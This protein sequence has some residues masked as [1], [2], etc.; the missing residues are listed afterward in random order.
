M[1]FNLERYDE[2]LE[3]AMSVDCADNSY[4][5]NY[6][7]LAYFK[8]NKYD[9]AL[10]YAL[11]ALDIAEF[12]EEDKSDIKH[13]ANGVYTCYDALCESEKAK[14]IEAKYELNESR[15][16][17]PEELETLE[18]HIAKHFGEFKNVF[19]EVVSDELH[20]DIYIIEP[21]PQRDFYT[22]VTGGMGAR[23]MDIPQEFAGYELERA[24]LLICLPKSWN[25]SSSNERDY[26]PLRWLKILARLPYTDDTWLADGHTIPTGEALAGSEFEC[27]LLERPYSFDGDAFACELP[28]GE[29]VKFYQLIP[30]YEEEMEYKLQ[31]GSDEL[32]ELFDEDFSDVVDVKR[33][34]YCKKSGILGKFLKI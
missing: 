27:I 16:Y 28:N 5:N 23:A 19:H 13:Y 4:L 25:I 24:E 7:A 32:I 14:Q 10:S 34:N 26:R 12:N 33:K 1:L 22:L 11:K 17:L 31:N 29:K 9:S 21:T 2:V 18:S 15:D 3:C 20:I 6:I 30:L 8:L